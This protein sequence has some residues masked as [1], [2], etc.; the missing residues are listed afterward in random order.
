MHNVGVMG[1][2]H[3][4]ADSA[5]DLESAW[6]GQRQTFGGQRVTEKILHG[7]GV[8]AAHGEEVVNADDVFV[9]NFPGVAQLVDEALDNVVI[10][11][12]RGMQEFQNNFLV[13]DQIL[14]EDHR[15][16][17]P[18]PDT[19][20]DLIPPVQDGTRFQLHGIDAWRRGKRLAGSRCLDDRG[21]IG[22]VSRG[23][24]GRRVAA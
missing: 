12:Q 13:D 1:H 21:S 20:Y 10:G 9:G 4:S 3:P 18:S 16:E 6:H 17:A 5:H 2:A 22:H 19:T 8:G 7:D 14:H 23:R 24:S 15:P 11:S